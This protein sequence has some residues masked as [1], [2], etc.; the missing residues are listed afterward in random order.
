MPSRLFLSKSSPCLI[1]IL[2]RR[3]FLE[4]GN[5]VVRQPVLTPQLRRHADFGEAASL[6]GVT[7]RIRALPVEKCKFAVDSP[8]P[9][10]HAYHASHCT[11]GFSRRIHALVGTLSSS[12]HTTFCNFLPK[13]TQTSLQK[14]TILSLLHHQPRHA[15]ARMAGW[16]FFMSI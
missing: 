12:S 2:A 14:N 3:G 13:Q 16:L 8:L 11:L 5:N 7:M 10:G 6:V 15:F 9:L 1:L 4:D